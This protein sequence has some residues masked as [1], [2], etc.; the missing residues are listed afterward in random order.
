MKTY[1]TR[2]DVYNGFAKKT[3]G[4]LTRNDII[5]KGGKFISRRISER[6]KNVQSNPLGVRKL[7]NKRKGQNNRN[8]IRNSRH[9]KSCKNNYH[10]GSMT[11]T[12]RRNKKSRKNVR[13]VLSNNKINRYLN[14]ICKNEY[15]PKYMDHSSTLLINRKILHYTVHYVFLFQYQSVCH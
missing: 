13:F 15:Y 5:L 3:R 1:G 8:I 11:S 7:I 14:D 12:R 9:S 2:E 10:A 4:G 6:M